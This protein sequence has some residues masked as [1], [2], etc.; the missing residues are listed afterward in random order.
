VTPQETQGLAAGIFSVV[1][2]ARYSTQEVD[3]FCDALK[4]FKIGYS[5]GGPVSLV[6][7]Y[8]L[9]TARRL[10]TPQL[11]AGRVV[12][13]CIGLEDVQD[14]QHDLAHALQQLPS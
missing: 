11:Q 9:S 4:L 5:W 8:H 12:R 7:P 2:D 1:V 13:L 6:V 14:L 3:A 10:A